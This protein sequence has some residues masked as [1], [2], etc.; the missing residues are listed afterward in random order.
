MYQGRFPMSNIESLNGAFY[1]ECG[2]AEY[3]LMRLYNLAIVGGA[4]EDFKAILAQGVEYADFT[5]RLRSADDLSDAEVEQRNNSF[6]SHFL[7]IEVHHLKHLAIETLLRLFLGH[8]GNP[9]CPWVEISKVT[10]PR[11]FKELVHRRIVEAAEPDL[12]ACVLETILGSSPDP[13]SSDECEREVADN[14]ASLLRFF[15]MEWLSEAKSY[16]ATKHGLT[17]IPGDAQFGLGPQGEE[18]TLLGHGDSLTHLTY[19]KSE[20][21][22]YTWSYTVRWIEV[23]KAIASIVVVQQMVG[24]I[25]SVARARYGFA[26]TISVYYLLPSVFSITN[27]NASVSSLVRQVKLKAFVE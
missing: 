23:K 21:G 16:N 20:D 15:A 5:A 10:H 7:R 12:R 11:K 27:L 24:S 8:L 13:E 25:W 17:A 2:P 18:P 19:E 14:L 4:P 22:Y 6:R 3:L 9:K 1:Q 26:T